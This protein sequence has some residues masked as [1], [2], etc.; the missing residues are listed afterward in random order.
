MY[1]PDKYRR[2]IQH[3]TERIEHGFNTSL[4][5]YKALYLDFPGV[6]KVPH[7]DLIKRYNRQLTYCSLIE[8]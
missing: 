7:R 2:D 1:I 4:P 3:I 6:Y 8:T 5:D